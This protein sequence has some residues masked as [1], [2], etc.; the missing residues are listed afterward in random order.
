VNVEASEHASA[1]VLDRDAL[2]EQLRGPARVYAPP[3]NPLQAELL[4]LWKR[5]LNTDAIGIDDSF[6]DLGGTSLLSVRLFS[7]VQ[8]RLGADLSPGVLLQTSS[9]R[10]LAGL[11]ERESAALPFE[12]VVALNGKISGPAL[13]FLHDAEGRV[14][15]YQA[16]AEQLAPQL[17]VYGVRPFQR[18]AH[19]ALHT[20]IEDMVAHSVASIRATQPSGPYCLGGSWSAGPLAVEVAS[21]LHAQGERVAFVA[22]LGADDARGLRRSLRAAAERL[23][24]E[25]VEMPAASANEGLGTQLKQAMRLQARQLGKQGLD[26]ARVALLQRF[27][28]QGGE[29]PWFLQHIPVRAVYEFALRKH[30]PSEFAGRVTWFRPTPSRS[31][32]GQRDFGW[33][34]RSVRVVEVDGDA[35]SLLTA[36]HVARIASEIRRRALSALSE[37]AGGES[38]AEPQSASAA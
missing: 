17:A 22:V 7:E 30:R 4:E 26:Y 21:A 37:E 6:F 24:L 12:S 10:G 9:I 36:P 35:R 16:L 27:V 32:S 20:R 28:D 34:A 3:E 23:A 5:L 15:G 8:R 25:T 33:S 14:D 2:L 29:I 11:I 38:D 31:P 18:H 1:A 19:P 13:F